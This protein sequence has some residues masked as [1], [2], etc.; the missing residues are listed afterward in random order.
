MLKSKIFTRLLISASVFTGLLIIAKLTGVLQY[1]FLPAAGSEPT[2]KRNSFVFFSNALSHEKFKLLVYNQ[3]NTNFDSGSYV[4]RLV[5]KENDVLQIIDG[6]LLIN[7]KN[8]DQNFTLKRAYKIDRG[9]VNHLIEN[10]H[11]FNDF[12][13]FGDDYFIAQL[14]DKDLKDGFFYE[15]YINTSY[16]KE[17]FA[18]FGKKWNADNFGPVK[19]PMGKLFFIGDN[20]NASLDSRYCGFVDENEV[21]G[22]VFIPKN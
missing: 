1:A 11:D 14:S 13:P 7:N 22:R 10:G 5:A 16:D 19:I 2:V 17:I 9:F 4:Q 6:E 21:V 3:K 12:Y 15:R 20:R 18:T 8:V